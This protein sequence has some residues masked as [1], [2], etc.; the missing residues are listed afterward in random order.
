MWPRL[1]SCAQSNQSK[2]LL[3]LDDARRTHAGADTHGH[4]TNFLTLALELWEKCRDLPGACAPER[5]PEGNCTALGVHFV[6][7]DLQMLNRHGGLGSECF[8]DLKDVDIV[9]FQLGLFE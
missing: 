5:V 6:H 7:G 9:N 8:I 3:T 1:W 4:H 2:S